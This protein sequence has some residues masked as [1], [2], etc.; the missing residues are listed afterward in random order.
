M[1]VIYPDKTAVI[2][3]DKV[4]NLSELKNQ[5]GVQLLYP[6]ISKRLGGITREAADRPIYPG[7]NKELQTKVKG[8]RYT[9]RSRPVLLKR[10]LKGFKLILKLIRDNKKAVTAKAKALQ[11]KARAEQ[12]GWNLRGGALVHHSR[13]WVPS[14]TR[15]AWLIKEAHARPG[16]AHCGANKLRKVLS[17]QYY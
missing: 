2:Y 5:W 3:P 6:K 1:A 9:S 8:G 17:A 16:A 4:A 14:E 10:K 7:V 12:D 11:E 13:L 15:R